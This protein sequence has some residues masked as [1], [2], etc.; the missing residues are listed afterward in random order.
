MQNN[1]FLRILPRPTNLGAR[2]AMFA[3]IGTLIAIVLGLVSILEI[4]NLAPVDIQ[5]TFVWIVLGAAALLV[6]TLSTFWIVISQDILKPLAKIHSI[7]HHEEEEIQPSVGFGQM[8]VQVQALIESAS[9]AQEELDKSQES[10]RQAE[11]LAMVGKL[12]A[13]VAHSVRN[14]LTSV[15]LRL[16]SL[17][18]SLALTPRQEED[19]TVITDAI[20]HVDSIVS[21][22]LEFSRRP[23]LK[24][25]KTSV[26]RIVD[27]TMQLLENRLTALPVSISVKRAKDLPLIDGDA[28]QLREALLNILL[29]GCEAMNYSG[30]M[31]IEEFLETKA[32]KDFIC[33][34]IQDS[35]PGILPSDLTEIFTPFFST[36]EQGTGLGL[37][38]AKGILQ[39]H[40]G[41]IEVASSAKTGTI[42]TLKIPVPA[43]GSVS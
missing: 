5:G 24:I 10:L 31:L 1:I 9:Q 30:S 23:Q 36:K 43:K 40:G 27:A 33:I 35:G 26:K 13:G 19:F 21:N 22:F 3:I 20:R 32:G 39:E 16:F 8:A 25:Q 11:K 28:E 29:N 42:F 6:L 14:P 7:L 4:T 34:R 41:N 12:A 17:E 15:K 38:I 18:R 37:P 2:L